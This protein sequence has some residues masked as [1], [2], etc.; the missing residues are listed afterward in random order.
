MVSK[1][2]ARGKKILVNPQS[3]LLSAATVIMSMIIF[4]RFLGLLRQRVLAHFF[5]PLELSLFF[6]A[7]RLPDSIFEVFV[8]GTFSSAFIPVFSESFRKKR[9]VAW[10]TAALVLNLGVFFFLIFYLLLFLLADKF[11]F[12]IA[13]G[14]SASERE[15]VVLLTKVLFLSQIFFVASYVLTGVLESLRRF[16]IP[17]LAPIFYN[18]GIISG[19]FFFFRNFGIFAPVIGVLLGSF[20]HFLIQLPLA[21]KLGFRFI[22]KLKLTKEVKKIG[23]LALP[24]VVET[25][26]LQFLKFAELFF[27]SVIS[28]ASYTYYTFGNSLQL[29]PIGLFGTSIAKA[30]LPNLSRQA[31]NLLEFRRILLTS[32]KSVIFFVAPIA[33]LLFVLRIPLVRL[34]Y[35]TDIFSWEATIQTSLVVSAFSLGVIFQSVI[36]L[37]SRAFYAIHDTKTPV[38]VSIGSIAIIVVLDFLFVE[39]F[40]LS[41][42]SLALSYSI[43]TGLQSMALFY[44]INRKMPLKDGDFLPLLKPILKIVLA[45][46]LSGVLMFFVLKFFDRSVWVKRLSFVSFISSENI[47]FEKFV[48]DTR[49]TVNLVI[50]TFF[51]SLLGGASYFFLLVLMKSQEVWSFFELVRKLFARKVIKPA[52]LRKKTEPVSTLET[53]T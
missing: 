1:I 25:I 11:Y 13:P 4:S 51:V 52:I 21:L 28:T 9:K 40:S 43:G 18:L 6:A 29:V 15:K 7:F 8:F 23:K 36:A 35:G 38:L 20:F 41:V 42:W 32:L 10:E 37:L 53:P 33:S 26:F 47:P 44:L 17:A 24:R 34:I 19:T 31:K 50:L 30:A 46:L 5:S 27:S 39:I 14:F 3:S 2:F 16:L 48:L 49:Y 12:F 45:S 22:P